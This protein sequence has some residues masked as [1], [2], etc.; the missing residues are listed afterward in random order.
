MIP[1][2]VK[3]TSV[4]EGIAF[5]VIAGG[6]AAA[7]NVAF[8]DLTIEGYLYMGGIDITFDNVTLSDT[9][10]Q[11]GNNN[12]DSQITTIGDFVNNGHIIDIDPYGFHFHVQDVLINNGEWTCEGLIFEGDDMHYIESLGANPFEVENITISAMAGDVTITN[13]LYLLNTDLKLSSRNL[14]IPDAGIL[15]LD[16]SSIQNAMVYGGNF[17]TCLLYTSPSP[18]D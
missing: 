2:F 11:W 6:N 1:S 4:I 8:E 9:I 3:S 7:I 14:Y 10:S 17:S 16:N 12:Y 13:E 18:R 15:D 5:M